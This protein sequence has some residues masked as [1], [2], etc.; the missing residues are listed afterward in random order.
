[1]NQVVE[2]RNHVQLNG[3]QLNWEGGDGVG[4]LNQVGMGAGRITRGEGW[5]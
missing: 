2:I 1:M 5:G 4:V 3:V